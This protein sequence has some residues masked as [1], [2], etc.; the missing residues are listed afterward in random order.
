MTDQS[1]TQQLEAYLTRTTGQETRVT[2]MARIPGG[3]SRETYR[4]DTEAGG[5]AKALILR[6]DPVG[7]LIDTDR[8]LEFL[9]FRSFHGRGLPVP[10]AIALEE[11]GAELERPFFIMGRIDGGKAASPFSQPPYGEHA[12]AI[13]EQFFS[14]MGAIAAAD[15]ASLPISEVADAPALDACWKRELDYWSGVIDADELHPQ[16]IVRAAIR[17]LRANP[18]PPAQKL[19]VVHGD[20]RTGNFLHDG[21]GRIIAL[22]DWEMAHLGDPLEDLGWATDPLW[23]YGETDRVCGMLPR[24]QAIAIWEKA[25]GLKVDPKAFAWWELFA[26]VKGQAIWTSSAKE[27]RDGGL[28]DPILGLSGWY[29]ARRQ[30][31]ILAERLANF[32]GRL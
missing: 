6:R 32:E 16:P 30:D 1:L 24:D 15:P 5:V 31:L 27:F 26:S 9:A 12:A 23:C 21:E 29:T 8:R 17:R 20:Y 19:S 14:H 28:K 11:D 13:G 18:P 10:E 3:A 22:L 25:S 2:M 4:F 7:S